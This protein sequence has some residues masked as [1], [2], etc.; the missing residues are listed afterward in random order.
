MMALPI[1][2]G[3]VDACVIEL[4]AYGYAHRHE[5]ENRW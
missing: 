3:L 4:D 5:D 2:T 1:T